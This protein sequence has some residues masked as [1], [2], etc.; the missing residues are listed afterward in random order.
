MV[1][2]ISGMRRALHLLYYDRADITNPVQTTEYGL[3]DT[4]YLDEPTYAQVPGQMSYPGYTDDQPDSDRPAIGM[5][6]VYICDPDIQVTPGA[7]ITI[8]RHTSDGGA[9]YHTVTGNVTTSSV[10][11]GRSA[12]GEN[13]QEIP[14]TVV[15]VT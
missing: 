13:H 14:F 5:D 6:A 2:N 9:G 12:V 10:S 4:R 15:A 3:T 7:R 11:A 1:V 8:T